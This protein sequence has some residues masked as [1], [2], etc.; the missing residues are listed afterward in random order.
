[1]KSFV[2]KMF[3]VHTKIECKAS[4]FKFLSFEESYRKTSVYVTDRTEGL[5]GVMKFCFQ[6]PSEIVI[7]STRPD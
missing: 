4:V 7:V 6:N 2:A 5:T 3:S 1:M